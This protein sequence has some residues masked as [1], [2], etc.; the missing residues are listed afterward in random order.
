MP[1]SKYRSI[2][3]SDV[4][5]GSRACQADLL[6]QFLKQ[7]S[8]QN[9]YLVGDIFDLWKLKSSRYW[10]QSHSNVV[11]RVLTAAKRG[12]RVYYV[13]G[14]H[15]E[16]LRTWIS[17][18]STFGNIEMANSFD[19]YTANGQRFLVTHGD[20]FDGI[21][22]Y[23]KWL[24]IL[25]DKAHSFLLWANTGVNWIRK[26]FG[27]DYWSFSSFLKTNT[28]QAVAFITK[29]QS[30]IT[31]HARD[32]AYHGVICGHIHTPAIDVSADGFV[33]F[34][35]GDWCETLSALVENFDGT[36]ELLVWDTAGNSMRSSAAWTCP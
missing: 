12:T 10:P 7:N 8:C 27:K 36:L 3:I 34:N 20:L 24:S 15:D 11:R 31:Q 26:K 21:I 4:H 30:H 13:L 25:G 6:A 16:H 33:Y 5:L 19:H 9:L 32:E 23:H 29:F 28:K 18:I 17:D 14:N 2:F 1:N 35:T 22:R